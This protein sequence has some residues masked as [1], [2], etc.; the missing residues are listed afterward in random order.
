MSFHTNANTFILKSSF[1]LSL[2]VKIICYLVPKCPI[3]TLFI[4]FCVNYVT[5]ILC[6]VTLLSSL[7]TATSRN[8]C[9]VSL[10]VIRNLYSILALSRMYVLKVIINKLFLKYFNT[11]KFIAFFFSIKSF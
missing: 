7:I 9:L 10:D 4:W 1:Q 6:L 8:V 11:K 2:S 5:M 3:T